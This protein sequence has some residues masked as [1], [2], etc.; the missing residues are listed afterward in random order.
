MLSA[1]IF[2]VITIM[3]LEKSTVFPEE[4]VILPSSKICNK[5]YKTSSSAFCISSKRIKEYGFFLTFSVR[6]PPLSNPI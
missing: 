4:S 6:T 5:Q 3:E 2:V 1:P